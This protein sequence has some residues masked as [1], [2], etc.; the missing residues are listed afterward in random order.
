M[1]QALGIDVELP[2]PVG[3]ADPAVGLLLPC[4]C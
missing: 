2:L 3:E 1:S 4:S